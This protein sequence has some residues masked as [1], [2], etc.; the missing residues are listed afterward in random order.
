MRNNNLYKIK[1]KVDQQMRM[2]ADSNKNEEGGAD[3]KNAS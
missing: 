2:N 1:I 3:G